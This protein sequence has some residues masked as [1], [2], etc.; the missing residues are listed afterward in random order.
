MR[1]DRQTYQKIY[2][3]LHDFKDVFRLSEEYAEPPGTLATILNQ[4]VVK[5]TRFKHRRIYSREQELFSKWKQGRSILDL[6]EYTGFPPTLMAA[7]IMKNCDI[8]KKSV[9]WFFKNI[10]LIENRRLRKEVKKALEVDHFFSPHAHEMQCKKGAMGEEVIRKWLDDRGILYCTEA[11]IRAKGDG[12][13]PDFVLAN[14]LCV[15]D[16]MVNW[17]ES[18]ALFGDDFEHEHYSKKQFREYAEIFGEGMVVYWYGCLE[19]LPAEGYLVKNHSFFDD[20]QEEVNELF[21][22][23]VYW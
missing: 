9:N 2:S 20:Y 21:N 10:D 16:L 4:K 1:M 19:D 7:L 23:L 11:E 22:Y 14:P 3:S 17:I 12:K 18:K 6:A 5:M 13:T 8:S 15:D